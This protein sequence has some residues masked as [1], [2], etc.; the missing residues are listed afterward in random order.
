MGA[1]DTMLTDALST[2]YRLMYCVSLIDRG[3][4]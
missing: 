3:N 1:M 4:M 2:L